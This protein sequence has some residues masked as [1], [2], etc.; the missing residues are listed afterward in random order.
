M[1][2]RTWVVLLLSILVSG[3]AFAQSAGNG[4]VRGH[5]RDEQGAV[6]PGATVTAVSPDAPGTYTAVSDNEG[7]Y[8]L[9]DLPP[10]TYTITTELTNFAKSIRSDVVVRAGLNLGLDIALKI[11]GVTDSVTVRAESPMLESKTA[12]NAV[13][14][15]G[16]FQRA[17]PLSPRRLW[18]DY[19]AVTPGVV[20]LDVG[21]AKNFYVNGTT[22]GSHVFQ[23]DGLDMM[24][25][26]QN[27][28][29]SVDMSTSVISDVQIKTSAIDASAPLGLGAIVDVVSASGGDRFSGAATFL[30]QPRQWND[31]NVPNGF[32]QITALRQA[33]LS[34]GGPIL[35]RRA[36]LFVAYRRADN[37]IAVAR[38]A[39][40]TGNLRLVVPGFDPFDVDE[41]GNFAFVKGVTQLRPGQ[42]LTLTYNR[43][44]RRNERATP[45]EAASFGESVT[46]GPVL[47]A[48]LSSVW[49]STLTTRLLVS[50]NRK[51]NDT[52]PYRTDVPAR[53]VHL[54][55]ILSG[56][57]LLGTGVIATLDN[58]LGGA[59]ATPDSK[60]TVAADATLFRQTGLGSHELQ[61]GLWAQPR[62]RD[63]QV[64]EYAAGGYQ[65]EEVILRDRSNPAL[66]FVPFHRQVFDSPAV[67]LSKVD[68]RDIAIYVQ[69]AWRPTG[70]LTV[71]AGVRIDAIKRRDGLFNEVL[72]DST[73]IGPR[74]GAILRLS[75]SSILRGNWG[76]VHENLSVNQLTAGSVISGFRDLYDL[77]FDGA[78]ET[79]FSNPSRTQGRPDRVIDLENY[80]QEHADEWGLGYRMQLPGEISADAGFLQRA[81]KDRPA[82]V[83]TNAIYEGSVFRGLRNNNFGQ[84]TLLT[85][86][87]WNWVV[88]KAVDVRVTKQT[89][90][91]R[92]LAGY[93]RRW[94][95]VEGTWSP[96]DPASVIQPSAF[97]ND[98]GLGNISG[99]DPANSLT[100][101]NGGFNL[102]WRDHTVT[103]GGTYIAP[104]GVM[105]SVGYNFQSGIW[106]GPIITSV[107]PDSRFGPASVPL[108]TG[109]SFSNPLATT[110]RFA[111]PTR[112]EGQF[113]LD[114]VHELNLRIG[115]DF[116]IGKSKIDVAVDG[117][118]VTNEGANTLPI[119]GATNVSFSPLYR[120]G[121]MPQPPRSAQLS[122]GVAF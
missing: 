63:E 103:A 51:G 41:T 82:L 13:N 34:L 106:S 95:H 4:S 9:L 79:T 73:E 52:V 77:D 75:E 64:I 85:K 28:S 65:L 12:V 100:A 62:L 115:R 93:T 57:R 23:V 16:D 29:L 83:E 90:R 109:G 61:F 91:I 119:L 97:P 3:P 7:F 78:F 101:S 54:G 68:S 114:G 46:G 33:D 43:D 21:S 47:G 96:N 67:T 39:Q 108:V 80:H 58:S 111:F 88:Y 121:A 19:L 56:G 70:R 89:D 14:V 53:N 81:Y 25:A 104:G 102:P 71:T 38:T 50:Y 87:I 45:L 26:R 122:V 84:T 30:Y 15:S 113:T 2:G 120:Q 76:R 72:Q 60:S 48:R 49:G 20:S 11:G 35:Q 31:N 86:N 66:G 8:R 98:R 117:F 10:G 42:Q 74:F 55:T 32:P 99:V 59:F 69:D 116:R 107:A 6:L 22:Q 44:Y 36:W 37:S 110:L 105:L 27:S 112:G 92:F 94:R 5:V 17:L 24:S 1:R 118:N 40:Q 18:T